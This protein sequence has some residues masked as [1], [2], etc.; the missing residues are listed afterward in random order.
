MEQGRKKSYDKEKHEALKSTKI[1][2]IPK[3]LAAFQLHK[4]YI[5][6]GA[7]EQILLTKILQTISLMEM[8][9]SWKKNMRVQS[10]SKPKQ[11][12]QRL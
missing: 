7:H 3:K 2:V 6:I 11:S 5:E 10:R 9:N 4:K 1:N 12:L 8:G